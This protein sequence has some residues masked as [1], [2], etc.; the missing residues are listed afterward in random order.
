MKTSEQTQYSDICEPLKWTYI[1]IKL[2]PQVGVPPGI[3]LLVLSICMKKKLQYYYWYYEW[4]LFHSSQL[5]SPKRE[6]NNQISLARYPIFI[7][8][9]QWLSVER[10]YRRLSQKV[11]LI[12]MRCGMLR[13]TVYRLPYAAN[14]LK[15]FQWVQYHRT[16]PDSVL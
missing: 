5:P 16:R 4:E 14:H 3:T 13:I 2:L 8:S 7:F 9:I 1:S 15:T 11:Y 10:A 12:H 6:I